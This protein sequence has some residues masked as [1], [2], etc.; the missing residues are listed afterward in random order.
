MVPRILQPKNQKRGRP[1]TGIGT[2]VQVRLRDDLLASLDRWR[3]KQ[4]DLPNRPEAMRR[5]IEEALKVSSAPPRSARRE[6]G[7]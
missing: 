6:R 5:L 3:R 7:A 2:P 4:S 1:R